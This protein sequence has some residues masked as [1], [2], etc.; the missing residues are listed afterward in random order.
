MLT[1]ASD[2]LRA[3]RPF[4]SKTPKR[5]DELFQSGLNIVGRPPRDWQFVRSL[6]TGSAELEE[7]AKS[8]RQLRL[9][10]ATDALSRGLLEVW[11]GEQSYVGAVGAVRQVLSVES[12]EAAEPDPFPVS[13]MSMH[14][15]KGKEFDGVLIVE[16]KYQ[17]QLLK[18]DAN[19]EDD[20][21]RRRLLRVAI[22]SARE[23]VAFVRPA[24]ALELTPR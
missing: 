13:L 18:D 10:R 3:G 7:V 20:A 6:L 5:L 22:T 8:A 1:R 21:A 11:N 16:E 2:A 9:F 4:K 12:L 14:R 15:S 23:L 24:G 19:A 17:G